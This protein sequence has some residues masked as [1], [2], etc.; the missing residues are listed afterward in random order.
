M[1]NA[2]SFW[3]N[4]ANK[5]LPSA[6]WLAQLHRRFT[7]SR[8]PMRDKCLKTHLVVVVCFVFARW[9][10]LVFNEPMLC[11]LTN[12]VLYEQKL[13]ARDMYIYNSFEVSSLLYSIYLLCLF[14]SVVNWMF[15]RWF[16]NS[17]A[18]WASKCPLI[19]LASWDL[20]WNTSPND[21]RSHVIVF[22]DSMILRNGYLTKTFCA[23]SFSHPN[24]ISYMIWWCGQE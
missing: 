9:K 14:I 20:I 13:F 15:I 21:L 3:R 10:M 4:S 18:F 22:K 2:N 23:P 17:C 12:L 6:F 11:I 1:A 8:L 24:V 5:E 16:L 7:S 19:P